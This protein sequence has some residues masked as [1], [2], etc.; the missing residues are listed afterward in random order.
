[1][2]HD[3]LS[4]PGQ[5]KPAPASSTRSW[6]LGGATARRF[7]ATPAAVLGLLVTAQ[8]AR[9]DLTTA[10][11]HT[12]HVGSPQGFAT[13]RDADPGRT[14]RAAAL[15]EIEAAQVLW[16][17]QVPGG[18]SCNVLVDEAGRAFVAGQGRISQLGPDGSLQFSTA[19]D[20]AG[21]V[22]AALVGDGTRVLLTR[23]GRVLGWSPAGALVFEVA[24]DAPAPSGFSSLLPLPEGGVLV[25]LGPWLFSLDAA[26]S[27][28][29]FASLPAAAQHTL[30][31]ERRAIAVDERGR[32]YEWNRREPPRLIGAFSG[33]V[34]AVV[35][36]GPSLIGVSGRSIERL[37]ERG[38]LRELA[39][40]D[41]PAVAPLLALPAPVQP[42]A[43]QQDGA[44]SSLLT[45]SPP[46]PAPRR[47]FGALTRLDLLADEHGTVAWWAAEVPLHLETAPGA[48][49]E[50][51]EVRCA[52]PSSLVPAGNRR[53]IAACNSGAVWLIGPSASA[54]PPA[55]REP[56]KQPE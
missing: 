4:G 36:D 55:T 14:R 17:K 21:V 56:Q 34:A 1:M 44:W 20:F 6:G 51:G 19:T 39:R 31:A 33:T 3:C 37:D 8:A 10:L 45:G 18:V 49:R 41:A 24:L 32:V 35:A 46:S 2:K 25:S 15:P 7:C 16:Q 53:V 13:A 28:P 52:A 9:A 38:E 47:S 48:G 5:R 50:L 26:R 30:L 22:S 40:F 12:L 27:P 54:P 23:E 11:P 43:M 29:S 42:I